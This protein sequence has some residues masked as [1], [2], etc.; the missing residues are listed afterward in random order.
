MNGLSDGV[1]D[2]II[3]NLLMP[4]M[5]GFE[6]LARLRARPGLTRTRVIL[7]AVAH[8]DPEVRGLA[9]A[10]GVPHLISKAA[11]PQH[12]LDTISEAL[13]RPQAD[14]SPRLE[15]DLPELGEPQE[16]TRSKGAEQ[17]MVLQAAALRT[18]AN[19]IVITDRHGT[20]L[21]SNPSFTALTGYGP[22]EVLGKNPRL[23][24]S[25]KHAKEFYQQM[26]A[27]ILEGKIWHGEFTNR[28]KDGTLYHDEHT[29][30]PVRSKGGDIT[31][32]VAIMQD[33]T[34]R[35]AAEEQVRRLNEELEGRVRERTAQ[36]EAANRELEAFSYSVSHDLSAPLRHI[37]GFAKFLREDL[38]PALAGDGAH[39]LQQI[40]D[41]ARRMRQLI[42]DLL[43][44]SR[45][46]RAEFKSA[47]VE[48]GG[49]VEEVVR[50]FRSDIGDRKVVWRIG[51]LP[52]VKGDAAL[53]RQ[54]FVN[55][56]SN[57]VKYTRP[58]DE[59][60]IEIGALQ[61]S[62]SEAV[63]FV[64]DNGVGFDQRYAEKLFRVF[65]RLHL[66]ED[67][68]GTGIGLANVQRIIHRHGGRVWAEG[69]VSQGAT[70]YVSLPLM[71]LSPT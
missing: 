56:L 1:P 14:P 5:D 59:A 11:D 22:E 71:G 32:F 41:A 12:I 40:E 26:W 45:T 8:L 29:I 30:A 28:R 23:L 64:R 20:I 15:G 36:L 67:F 2:L 44:F 27:T 53:L 33:I 58:R 4:S 50:E 49:L 66:Q 51:N 21:W 46:A 69:R 35:K 24:K 68:E 17:Q 10:R 25:G 3:A 55:L 57:A 48:L 34:A 37:T 7:C 70:F 31:H 60:V 16:S 9:L 19:A 63:I 39:C 62:P 47:T 43:E 6:F 42:D 52:E 61:K 13:G 38:G 54:V 65:Q 18:A